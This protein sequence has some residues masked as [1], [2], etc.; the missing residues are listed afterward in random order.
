M[1][2]RHKSARPQ[3]RKPARESA[4]QV[5]ATYSR[6]RNLPHRPPLPRHLFP[7]WC[8]GTDQV[9]GH[10]ER[11]RAL[12]SSTIPGA[13]LQIC[14]DQICCEYVEQNNC[15]QQIRTRHAWR[16][17]PVD[18]ARSDHRIR[19]PSPAAARMSAGA[20]RSASQSFNLKDACELFPG[21]IW[22]RIPWMEA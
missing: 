5:P 15:Q 7:N 14:C 2:S 10:A 20:Q 16:R 3:Q 18:D 9:R 17:T 19:A 6:L 1:K 4:V 22:K 8:V 12:P 11:S 13:V 21:F